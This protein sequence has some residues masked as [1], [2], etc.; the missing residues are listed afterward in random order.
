M[1]ELAPLQDHE[2]YDPTHP[3]Y[4]YLGGPI[5]TLKQIRAHAQREAYGSR[6][7]SQIEALDR[8]QEPKRSKE[9]NELLAWITFSLH[10]DI[11]RYRECVRALHD[12]RKKENEQTHMEPS[13][14]EV[15]VS[16]SLK[17]AHIFHGFTQLEQLQRVP[18][19]IDLFG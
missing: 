1:N 11:S 3:W 9:R 16:M 7:Y 15:D 10:R 13:C 14:R 17:V 8:M 12:A 19:Q 2:G 4:Y 5:P 6:A 18:Q